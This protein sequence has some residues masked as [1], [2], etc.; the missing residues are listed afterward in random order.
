MGTEY[1]HTTEQVVLQVEGDAAGLLNDTE[2]LRHDE[3]MED[4]F[5]QLFNLP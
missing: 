3:Y 4:V 1:T 5:D 2:N